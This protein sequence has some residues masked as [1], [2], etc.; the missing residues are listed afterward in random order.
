M[1]S[2]TRTSERTRAVA[3][4]LGP[5]LMVLTVT[6]VAR[7]SQMPALVSDFTA[8][9]AW[10]WVT[11]AFVLLTGLVMVSLHT[12]WRGAPAIIVSVL[13]WVIVVKGA[14]LL[15]LPGVSVSTAEQ[16]IGVNGWWQALML[17]MTLIG[18]YLAV[19]GWAPTAGRRLA[20]RERDRGTGY[21]A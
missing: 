4:V 3:R 21:A 14:F 12:C 1:R 20:T 9:P 6:A 7:G 11:G 10:S 13:S 5:Y 16:L 15:A 18:L 19:V 8:G 2:P 17:I